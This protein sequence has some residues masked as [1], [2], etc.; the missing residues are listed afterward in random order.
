MTPLPNKGRTLLLA[1]LSMLLFPP[2]TFAEMDHSAHR[3]MLES[4]GNL[5]RS[6][7]RYVVPDVVLINQ[8]GEKVNLN[9]FLESSEP[10]ALNF[11]FTTCTTVCP[12]L[13]SSFRQMQR[14]LGDDA[15]GLHLISI[16][17]D[18][19][20]DTP[21][22]LNAYAQKVDATR[23]WTFLTGDFATIGQVERAFNAYTADKM[24]H[25]PLYLFKLGPDEPW[26]RIDG[27]ASGS[28]LAQIYQS[29][30]LFR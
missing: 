15:Q 27:L 23:N 24:Q 17:I 7:A 12:I 1:V 2:L 29:L 25:R 18:P 9:A 4:Q 3:A 19:E 13:T 6:Q 16:T 26:V 14:Q 30:E 21:A 8:A 5:N 22:V 20:Y 10:Y 28:E 11:I